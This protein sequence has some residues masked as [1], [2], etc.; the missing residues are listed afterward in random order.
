MEREA[1][2]EGGGCTATPEESDS[3]NDITITGN[4]PV[5]RASENEEGLVRSSAPTS[6]L[7]L[8]PPTRTH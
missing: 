7:P 5:P 1:V 2:G 8:Q 6:K 3:Y 4:L